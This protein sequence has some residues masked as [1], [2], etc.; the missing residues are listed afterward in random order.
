MSVDCV[1]D[2]AEEPEYLQIFLLVVM[3]MRGSSSVMCGQIV[4]DLLVNEII[5]KETII[6]QQLLQEV[7]LTGLVVGNYI[8]QNKLE[9]LGNMHLEQGIIA[10]K[11]IDDL[12]KSIVELKEF[13]TLVVL[14]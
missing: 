14:I 10:D 4:D 7:E 6:P 3:R 12:V 1:A 11:L 9:P 5:H 2:Y 8:V 13:I